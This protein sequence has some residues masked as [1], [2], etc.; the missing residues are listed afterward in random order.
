MKRYILA[1][2][3][4][5]VGTAYG[6]C[7]IFT[8]ADQSSTLKKGEKDVELWTTLFSGK[9]NYYFGVEHGFNFDVGLS[10]RMQATLGLNY[11]YANGIEMNNGRQHYFS[12]NSYS[13]STGLLYKLSD[14]MTQKSG[15]AIY[16]GYTQGLT[17]TEFQGKIIL[18]KITNRIVQA[19]NLTAEY[20]YYKTFTPNADAIDIG[21]I[22]TVEIELNYG[23]AYK[24]AEGLYLG[25]ETMSQ[26]FFSKSKWE[27]SVLTLGPAISYSVEDKFNINFTLMP[28]VTDL[29]TIER[30]LDEN[31]K[32]MA[33][34]ILCLSL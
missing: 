14:M 30:E 4:I 17:Y 7:R 32:M 28:Q 23:L 12:V 25:F 26:N 5:S 15:S 16:L 29:K 34:L 9:E 18:D 2:I 3:F 27:S 24:V 11:G 19:F 33:R 20:E 13:F 8:Y 31:N 1:L 10:N 22:G 21:H 6:Q